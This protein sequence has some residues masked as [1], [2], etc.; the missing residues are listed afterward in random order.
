MHGRRLHGVALQRHLRNR[1]RDPDHWRRRHTRSLL[2]ARGATS[3]AT[4]P[5]VSAAPLAASE[6]KSH[7]ETACKE[8]A[9]RN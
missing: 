2:G 5:W 6:P 7:P 3:T 4:G 8:N 9:L 1:T